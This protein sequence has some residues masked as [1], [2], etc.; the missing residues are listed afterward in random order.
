MPDFPLSDGATTSSTLGGDLATSSGT[1]ITASATPNTKGAYTELLSST[2]APIGGFSVAIQGEE[3]TAP[4]DF[5]LDISV[6]G[7]G[8]EEVIVPDLLFSIGNS[9][10]TGLLLTFEIP[11]SIPQ[12]IRIAARM[13]ASAAS[14]AIAC[15]IIAKATTFSSSGTG[16]SMIAVGANTA[17]SGGTQVDPGGTI[18]TKGSYTEIT[19]SLGR[20]IN[21]ILLAT[22]QQTNTANRRNKFLIDI[23]IG[24]SGSEE[25]IVS[26]YPMTATQQ[27]TTFLGRAVIPITIPVGTRISIRCQSADADSTDRL[28]DYVIYGVVI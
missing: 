17:D 21:G 4:T 7:A 27:E 12:G 10:D 23:A 26:N 14:E 9:M 6:G 2:T 22:G 11:V 19:A 8:S 5:L 16:A 3:L 25:I 24:G 13:Q 28:L 1:I 18:N 20:T 15:S